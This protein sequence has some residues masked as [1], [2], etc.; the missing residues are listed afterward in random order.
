[1]EMQVKMEKKTIEDDVA[2]ENVNVEL[3]QIANPI[4]KPKEKKRKKRKKRAYNRQFTN[5]SETTVENITFCNTVGIRGVFILLLVL[6]TATLHFI[7]LYVYTFSF[8]YMQR[9]GI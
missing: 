5:Y 3:P 8:T 4:E 6:G 9:E 7:A 1:M 2:T